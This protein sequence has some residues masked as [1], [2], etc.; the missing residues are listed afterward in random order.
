MSVAVGAEVIVAEHCPVADAKL[1][2]LATGAVVSV[3]TINWVWVLV[4]PTASVNFQVTVDVPCVLLVNEFE[5]VPTI[6][7]EQLSVAVGT[8]VIVAEHCPVADAKLAALATG[9]VVSVTTINWVWVLVFPLPSLNVHVTV[10]VPC[11]VLVNE[12]EVV[13]TIVPEQLSVAVGAEVIEAEH[14]PVAD[15]K[16]AALATGA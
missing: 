8:A 3:T 15:A 1:A 4:F 5:V 11:V 13:P 9:A 12:F 6:V 7:P 10:D 2:A 14:C 16:L